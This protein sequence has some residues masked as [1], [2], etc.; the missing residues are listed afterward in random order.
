MLCLRDAAYG[1]LADVKASKFYIADNTVK[2]LAFYRIFRMKDGSVRTNP[3]V[4][5]P[6]ILHPLSEPN[7]KM[8]LIKIVREAAEDIIL[9]NFG[10]H[11]DC[12]GGDVI[13]ADWPGVMR[14]TIESVYPDTF[15][16][17]IQGCEGDLNTTNVK[18]MIHGK[19]FTRAASNGHKIAGSVLRVCDDA[20]EISLNDI[21]FANKTVFV[22]TNLE[23]H[24]LDEARRIVELHRQDRDDEIEDDGSGITT[25]VSEAIRIIALEDG[26]EEF[27]FNLSA[28]RI[29]DMAIVGLPGEPFSEIGKRIIENSPFEK[30]L[31]CVLTDGGEIYFPTSFVIGEG[32]Y[33]ARSSVVKYGADDIIV[34]NTLVLLNE[35]K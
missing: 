2:N 27:K 21:S 1:A 17:F 32:G 13:S 35:L 5:N 8:T 30:T 7:D 12:I 10:V 4:C 18:G 25:I 11:A 29:G 31:I 16:V 15:C 9:V 33:E 19:G 22:P 28:I 14:D 23:N 3:G 34:E 24:R 20:S 6:D 26:S